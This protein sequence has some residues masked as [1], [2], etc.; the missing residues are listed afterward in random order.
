M[1]TPASR[2]CAYRTASGRAKWPNRDPIGEKGGVNLYGFAENNPVNQMDLLGLWGTDVHYFR[3]DRWARELGISS[4]SANTIGGADEAIDS[5]YDPTTLSDANWS[6]HFNRAT[7]GDSRL[8]HRDDE[9]AAARVRCTWSMGNDDAFGAG[10]RLG[11]A[12]HPLQDWVAHGDFNR[13]S[14]AP[15]LAG[16][17][18]WDQRHYWH[19]WDA[20]GMWTTNDPDDVNL[21]ANGPD[22]RATFSVIHLGK[23]LSNGDMTFWTR[24]H[25]GSQRI[26][27]TERETK[28]LLS[29]F[30]SYVRQHG[31]PCGECWKHYLGGN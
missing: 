19:N 13:R 30:Q 8:Q 1:F 27:L 9:L 5:L 16:V 3:T 2:A 31:K 17:G 23:V 15:S 25:P 6:W 7:S 24:F 22:G 14:E 18:I 26:V 29:G 28:G 11:H 21:D 20:G 4:G 12:L 10:V